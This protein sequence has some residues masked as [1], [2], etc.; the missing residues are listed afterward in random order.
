MSNYIIRLDDACPTMDIDKWNKIE[1]LLDKYNV[2][3]IVAVIPFNE[4][5]NMKKSP[6]D[7]NFW[8]KVKHWE[9]KGWKIA[10]H[11]F[12]HVY[13]TNE[14]GLV[15]FN[16]RSEFAGL[17]Y[18]EQVVKIKKG[19]EI[20]NNNNIKTKIWVAPS[21]TFDKNTLKAL[22]DV[23]NINIISDGIAI[24]PFEKYGFKWIPQQF[25]YFRKMPFGLWTS[26]Y[27][28]NEMKVNEFTKLELFLKYNFNDF[29]DV[30]TIRFNKFNFSNKIFSSIY[31]QL[32][33]I[34]K[35]LK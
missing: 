13:T 30:E 21:H 28:P 5:E 17:P 22:K 9:N 33:K 6:E 14:S 1:D 16:N 35:I 7:E 4:D 29:I 15:P 31:W 11:G 25:W 12:N 10:L 26:C 3:P 8:M 2:K 34:K 32:R 18:E 19:I 20:F 27:H 23:S 24:F